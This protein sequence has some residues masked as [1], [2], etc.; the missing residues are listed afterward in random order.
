MWDKE[1]TKAK[2]AADDLDDDG[3]EGERDEDKKA[4]YKRSW[5]TSIVIDIRWSTSSR[6]ADAHSE[7]AARDV[8]RRLALCITITPA[9][10]P[11]I[12][13]LARRSP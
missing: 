13:S 8:D 3:G 5:E 9:H 1:T 11:S 2:V 12:S 7:G 10:A 4:C 6:S